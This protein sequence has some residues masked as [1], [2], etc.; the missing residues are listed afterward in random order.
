MR[1][2]ASFAPV[3]SP[4]TVKK[5]TPPVSIA[6]R[7]AESILARGEGSLRFQMFADV[8]VRSDPPHDSSIGVLDRLGPRQE[9][10]VLSIG[11]PQRI[12]LLP[13]TAGVEC[14]LLAFD[15]S[16]TMIGVRRNL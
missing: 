2:N 8:G 14:R 16:S 3:M 4:S 13:Y 12:R 7:P 11:A 9:P 10:P 5:I 6:S 15:H 1:R